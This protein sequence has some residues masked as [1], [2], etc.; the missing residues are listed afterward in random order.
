MGLVSA[1]LASNFSTES[2]GCWAIC[3]ENSR[4]VKF[5]S[6]SL[7]TTVSGTP[8][9]VSGIE[10]DG[11]L[12]C[13]RCQHPRPADSIFCNICG[14]RL[15]TPAAWASVV[16]TPRDVAVCS[17]AVGP[18]STLVI[19]GSVLTDCLWRQRPADAGPAGGHVRD[20]LLGVANLPVVDDGHVSVCIPNHGLE[21]FVLFS[22]GTHSFIHLFPLALPP[23]FLRCFSLIYG[24]NA[25]R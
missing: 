15:T 10:S 3:T 6:G 21:W 8:V 20:D 17:R 19:H 25:N 4:L 9:V 5:R 23:S 18:S 2:G 12:E 7:A 16:D 11:S 13:S 1:P 14:E 24:G 22:L